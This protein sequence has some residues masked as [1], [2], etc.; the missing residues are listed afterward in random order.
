M[1]QD[2]LNNQKFLRARL[3]KNEDKKTADSLY[4][5]LAKD[6][7]AEA[8]ASAAIAYKRKGDIVSFAKYGEM[9]IANG[10]TWLAWILGDCYYEAG[11][12]AEAKQYY[13]IGAN[14]YDN[15]NKY[16]CILQL[17]TIYEKGLGVERSLPKAIEL[18]RQCA[19]G[20]LWYGTEAKEK[21]DSLGID[22]KE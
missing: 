22:D 19:K 8:Y 3:L 20:S 1:T 6:G 16:Y 18:Y 5:E 9:G 10:D 21:L 12:Y 15:N 4:I 17:G 7:F 13:E 2:D 11:R 14:A